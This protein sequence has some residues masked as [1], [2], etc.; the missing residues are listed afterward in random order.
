MPRTLVSLVRAVLGIAAP[1]VVAALLTLVAPAMPR[2]PESI[3]AYVAGPR[4]AGPEPLMPWHEDATGMVCSAA[5]R[6][7]FE[8]SG[9]TST[10]GAPCSVEFGAEGSGPVRSCD[11][12][13]CGETPRI[14]WALTHPGSP[15]GP[16][17]VVG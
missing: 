14:A 17:R 5:A 9:A 13:R 10:C 2:P 12:R 6:S 8:G 3:A 15:R 1:S 4:L 7:E 16:P 11:P